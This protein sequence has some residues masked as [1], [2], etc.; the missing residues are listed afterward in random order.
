MGH[1]DSLDDLRKVAG[2]SI[3]VIQKNSSNLKCRKR[4]LQVPTARR[5]LRHTDTGFVAFSCVSVTEHVDGYLFL[6]SIVIYI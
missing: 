6:Y 1:F 4:Q 2:I 3:S 5:C